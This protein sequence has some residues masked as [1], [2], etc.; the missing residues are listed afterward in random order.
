[1]SLARSSLVVFS[2]LMVG[3]ILAQEKRAAPDDK[4][5]P[6]P[7]TAKLVVKTDSYTLNKAQQG[8]EFRKS[9]TARGVRRLPEPPAVSIVLELKNPTDKPVTI[10]V[11]SDAGGLDLELKGI[12]AVSVA[13]IIAMTREFRL[14]RPVEIAPGKTHEIPITQLKYGLRGV[15][16]HAYWTE[17][18]EYTLGA[19]YRWP[20]GRDA[21]QKIL[22]ATA[23]PVKLT[24]KA[25]S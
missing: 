7:L 11:G 2:L 25:G 1:M 19:I 12:G 20:A 4:S 3:S 18:G 23:E 14:G 5:E 13:P 10:I 24:V 15:S 16:K 6:G 8:E 17:P 22:K 9:L 21:G